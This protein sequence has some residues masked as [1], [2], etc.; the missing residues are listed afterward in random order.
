M[1][2]TTH[3]D[4]DLDGL[5]DD[6]AFIR[7]SR[8]RRAVIVTLHGATDG[9]TPTAIAEQRDLLADNVRPTVKALRER[10]LIELLV[11]EERKH[12]RRYGLT[13]RGAAIAPH[14]AERD[15]DA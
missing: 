10:D 11:P 5:G 9:H 6:L 2:T 7:A 1:S 14:V 12:G 4:E 8:F 15:A 13:D 3:P